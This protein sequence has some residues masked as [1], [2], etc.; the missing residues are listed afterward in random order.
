MKKKICAAF[1]AVRQ[2][3]AAPTACLS[4][5]KPRPRQI[6]A[7]SM[8]CF[9]AG[10]F[11]ATP[12]AAHAETSYG[13]SDWSVSFTSDRQ[14]DSNFKTSDMD[15][16]IRG[17][18]PGDNAI[19]TLNLKNSNTETTDWYLMNEVLYSLEDRSNNENT[20]GGA[21]TYRLVYEGPNGTRTL[22]DSDT[23]GGE[24]ESQAG[25]GLHQATN[26]LDQRQSLTNAAGGVDPGER[27]AWLFLDT[28][29]NSQAGKV[30]LEVALDGDTQGND[31]QDTLADLQMRFG[32]E[33]NTTNTRTTTPNMPGSPRTVVRTGD[34]NDLAPYILLACISGGLLLAFAAYTQISR[35][36]AKKGGVAHES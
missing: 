7:A 32:V 11:L 16:I 34:E 9:M 1:H 29:T 23:I 31:Y 3:L 33:L 14:M 2:F 6:L 8:A 18:Q 35:S 15:D 17:M 22:F 25:E 21:Y 12:M 20:S 24:N 10:L 4:S 13:G 30:T 27:G 28:L 19:I 5:A 26:G 36:R